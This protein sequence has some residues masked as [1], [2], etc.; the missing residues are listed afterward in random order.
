MQIIATAVLIVAAFLCVSLLKDEKKRSANLAA[1]LFFM[2]LAY[3]VQFGV[4]DDSYTRAGGAALIVF[5][6]FALAFFE[7]YFWGDEL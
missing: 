3:C 2:A 6:I 4:G 7:L 1:C 5:F